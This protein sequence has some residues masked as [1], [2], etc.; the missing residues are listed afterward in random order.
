MSGGC[1]PSTSAFET[2]FVFGS[3][4]DST[5]TDSGF[6]PTSWQVRASEE[7]VVESLKE[8]LSTESGF[9]W[10]VWCP[11]AW[12]VAS[13]HAAL[14][15]SGGGVLLFPLR[16]LLSRLSYEG[17]VNRRSVVLQRPYQFVGHILELLN[18]SDLEA[19]L[20]P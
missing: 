19:A 20:H 10:R 6:S 18:Q 3:T 4:H 15:C 16:H 2:P 14:V 12:R 11:T 5:F 9:V 17:V 8:R 1:T 13:L 7:R